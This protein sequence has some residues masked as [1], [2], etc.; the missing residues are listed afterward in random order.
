MYANDVVILALNELD[1]AGH[2]LLVK[3]L[4]ARIA[5]LSRATINTAL[6]R[7]QDL[8]L[9]KRTSVGYRARWTRTLHQQNAP[10]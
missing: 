10:Y 8:G 3:E 4:D 1:D 5:N 2:G 6:S 7:L 9:V